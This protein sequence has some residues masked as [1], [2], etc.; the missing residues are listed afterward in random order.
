[1]GA[2]D[3]AVLSWALLHNVCP[4]ES[5]TLRGLEGIVRKT[6]LSP[7]VVIVMKLKDLSRSPHWVARARPNL[8]AES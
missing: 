7:F 3:K 1:M 6:P 5:W 8:S 2:G 4:E